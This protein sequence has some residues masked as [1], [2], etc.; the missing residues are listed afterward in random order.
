MSSLELANYVGASALLLLLGATAQAQAA[1][2][3]VGQPLF[4]EWHRLNSTGSP[5]AASEHEVMHFGVEGTT[6][7]GRYDKH[8]EPALAFANPPE[9]RYGVFIGADAASFVCQPAFPFH[10]CQNVVEVA[11]GTTRYYPPHQPPFDVRQQTIVVRDENGQEVM[12]Q[13]WISPGNFAC[14]WYRTFDEALAA[15]PFPTHGDCVFPVT[16]HDQREQ[17]SVRGTPSPGVH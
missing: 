5:P 12:W 17:P 2:P 8:P 1:T 9:G 11:E 14:P 15:N 10:P 13:Y 7:A 4:G 16:I 3:P 6:W